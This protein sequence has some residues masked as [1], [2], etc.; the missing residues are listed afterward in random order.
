MAHNLVLNYGL[1]KK[2]DVLVRSPGERSCRG[3][4]SDALLVLSCS[5]LYGQHLTK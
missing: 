2:M 3:T 5:A 4:L 1:D